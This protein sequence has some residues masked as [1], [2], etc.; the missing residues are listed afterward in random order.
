MGDG[1]PTKC[2][3]CGTERFFS[4]WESG[5]QE[6]GT[7]ECEECG[8]I[9]NESSKCIASM[10]EKKEKYADI[11][12]ETISQDTADEIEKELKRFCINW[13]RYNYDGNI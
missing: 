6:Y 11:H 4:K 12:I 3:N 9:Y 7:L 2:P 13:E 8:C 1:F 10:P 5:Y